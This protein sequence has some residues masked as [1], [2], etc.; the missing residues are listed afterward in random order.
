[1][2]TIFCELTTDNGVLVFMNVLA[3][4]SPT[5]PLKAC[6]WLVDTLGVKFEGVTRQKLVQSGYTLSI[7]VNEEKLC[8]KLTTPKNPDRL[9]I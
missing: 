9:L 6:Q 1:M 8:H 7:R 5:H 3:G 2:S 4:G